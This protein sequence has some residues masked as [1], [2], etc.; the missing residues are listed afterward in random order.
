[1]DSNDRKNFLELL[2]Q[3]KNCLTTILEMSEERKFNAVEEDVERFENFFNKRELLFENCKKL[4]KKI[5][6]FIITDEDKK[7]FFYKEVEKTQKDIQE[8]IRRIISIDEK[9]R[10]IMTKLMQNIKTSLLNLKRTKQVRQNYDEFYQGQS[11]GGFDS[12]K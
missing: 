4:D 8:I 1:M 7:S 6:E 10:K 5:K 9:N 2:A 3:K 11:Y 12:K